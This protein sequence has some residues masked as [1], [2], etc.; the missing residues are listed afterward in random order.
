MTKEIFITAHNIISPLG[1]STEDNY[2]NIKKGQTGIRQHSF[3]TPLHE[4]LFISKIEDT[5]IEEKFLTNA[6]PGRYTKVE[7]LLILSI[8]E[9]IKQ[10]GIDVKSQDF[11][12]IVSTTKGN[13]D[14]LEE[15]NKNVFPENR[16]YLWSL[17]DTLQQY[18]G[19]IHKPLILSNACISGVNALICASRLLREGL[20][21]HVLVSG[22]DITSRFVV[23][24]FQSFKAISE[25]PCKPFDKNRDGINL[26][27]GCGTLL[28]TSD[29]SFVKNVT[30]IKILGG[31]LSNDANHISGPSRT[32]DGLYLAISNALKESSVSSQEID[33]LNAH[34]TATLYNDEMESKAF[35][36]AGLENTSMN[37]L[38]GY[39]GHTLG[40]AG[41]IETIISM[42]SMLE[43]EIL[44]TLGFQET[45]TP[46]K[47]SVS[48][49]LIKKEITYLL[50][51][52][53]GFG[54]CNG[55]IVLKKQL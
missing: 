45:G 29:V 18:F 10:S 13:I 22:V 4:S 16:V 24:G 31:S 43:N 20:Y 9:T 42:I 23:S 8:N 39:F 19:T 50:K 46:E 25:K 26:G 48:N 32:G 6:K 1:F 15:E 47:V 40:A 7:K 52:A 44:P 12:I 41:T 21:K 17:A 37:G 27:E 14:L 36:L 54:G 33:L 11:F 49:T 55:A 3:P 2:T 5:L 38:K 34:G 30:K 51:T 35:K 28:L 53:S